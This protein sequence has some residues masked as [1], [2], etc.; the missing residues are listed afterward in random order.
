MRA[1][2]V[3]LSVIQPSAGNTAIRLTTVNVRLMV[4]EGVVRL[5]SDGERA[6]DLVPWFKPQ[7]L[8][9]ADPAMGR[10]PRASRA[11]IGDGANAE[12]FSGVSFMFGDGAI[13]AE[14]LARRLEP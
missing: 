10:A 1:A 3:L 11:T 13:I 8:F 5:M 9:V 4:D 7:Q 12:T 2:S 14:A 6:A